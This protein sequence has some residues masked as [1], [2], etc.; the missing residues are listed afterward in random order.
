MR[1]IVLSILLL[2]A[3]LAQCC[4]FAEPAA[5]GD[6]PEIMEYSGEEGVTRRISGAG[7]ARALLSELDVAYVE[8][9]RPLLRAK[10]SARWTVYATGGDGRYQ[11]SFGLYYRKGNTGSLTRVEYQKKSA[12][13]SFEAVVEKAGQYM[14]VLQIYDESGSSIEYKCQINECAAAEDYSNA[15]TV[16]GKV[17]EIAAQCLREAGSSDYAR[18][19]WLHD[20]LIY[21]ANYDYSFT[22]YYAEGVLLHGRGVCQSYALA[23][24]MLL[25]KVGIESLYISGTANGGNHG[26]NL[27][28]L[29]DAWYHVDCTWDDPGTGGSEQRSYFCLS[30][31]Q[32]AKDH[33]WHS[34][35]KYMPACES[36][37]YNYGLRTGRVVHSVAELR[38]LLEE[39]AR[40]RIPCMEFVDATDAEFDL[41]NLW[42]DVTNDLGIRYYGGSYVQHET[43]SYI[44]VDFG[45]GHPVKPQATSLHI[46]EERLQLSAG[47]SYKV[48]LSCGP[49]MAFLDRGNGQTEWVSVRTEDYQVEWNSSNPDV[50]TV[51]DGR[52]TA[53]SAGLAVIT[54]RSGA[55]VDELPVLVASDG[56]MTAH[57]HA[58]TKEIGQEAFLNCTGFSRILFDEDCSLSI[59]SRAF[60]GCTGVKL[61]YIPA[62]VTQIAADAFAGCDA[63]MLCA[64][65]SAA[66]RYALAQDMD[67]FLVEKN[68]L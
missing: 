31:A 16:A 2:L 6:L 40:S 27:V 39:M 60:A 35:W 20:W 64:E 51:E 7:K 22:Y 44:A 68:I 13:N 34:D 24:Q 56:G 42:R 30:D 36:E 29:G 63:V 5:L 66:H 38:A 37:E 58:D 48:L 23:Y 55:A 14:L 45:A 54:A 21:N 43:I 12:S 8:V 1:R 59:G 46:D 50:A 25:D 32:M 53:Q 41:W 62:G 19:L 61:I 26:W 67:V 4:A 15:N 57:I 3:L 18:A 47:E 49:G 9:D 11:Y 28:K 17:E 65:N 10:E 33:E 52:I